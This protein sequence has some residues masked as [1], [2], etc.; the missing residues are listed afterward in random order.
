MLDGEQVEQRCR[1]L[2]D[3]F[4]PEELIE[5]LGV[6][7]QDICDRFLDECLELKSEDIQ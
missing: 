4:T 6:S 1:L 3:R 7:T 5:L 2:C